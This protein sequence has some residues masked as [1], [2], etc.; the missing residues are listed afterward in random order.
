MVSGAREKPIDRELERPNGVRPVATGQ[1]LQTPNVIRQAT[2]SA[3]EVEASIDVLRR[4]IARRKESEPAGKAPPS[5]QKALPH[6]VA[7]LRNQQQ[8]A[9][10]LPAPRA[11][12]RRVNVVLP[13]VHAFA[14]G[15][16]AAPAIMEP[17]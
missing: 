6:F 1:E 11:L 7:A 4:E 14:S 15:S 8:L 5:A 3:R 2:I 13:R 12:A 16:N 9:A 17:R 10:S